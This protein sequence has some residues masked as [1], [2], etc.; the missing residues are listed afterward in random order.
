MTN[1]FRYLSFRKWKMVAIKKHNN[2]VCWK[3]RSFKS[4]IS[5]KSEALGPEWSRR[6]RC[7]SLQTHRWWITQGPETHIHRYIRALFPSSRQ[8]QLQTRRA[9]QV[10]VSVSHPT[11]RPICSYLSRFRPNLYPRR[12]TTMSDWTDGRQNFSFLKQIRSLNVCYCYCR[13]K[14]NFGQEKRKLLGVAWESSKLELECSSS[15]SS[16]LGLG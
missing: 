1:F 4:Q 12:Q 8:L 11:C 14:P 5:N 16:C 10:P 15:S 2:P 9:S 13:C 3:Y 6:K 7:S